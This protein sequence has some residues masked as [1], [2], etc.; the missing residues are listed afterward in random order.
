[1]FKN[2]SLSLNDFA[3]ILSSN[4]KVDFNEFSFYWREIYVTLWKMMRYQFQFQ[5]FRRKNDSKQTHIVNKRCLTRYA[6]YFSKTFLLKFLSASVTGFPL[7]TFIKHFSLHKQLDIKLNL[8]SEGIA[9]FYLSIFSI[10]PNLNSFSS[11][12]PASLRISGWCLHSTSTPEFS[13]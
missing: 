13:I 6:I 2:R 9:N 12:F 10:R 7:F 11:T 1:M 4:R 5:H 3:E 8:K